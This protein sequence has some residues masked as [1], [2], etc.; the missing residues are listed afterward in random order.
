MNSIRFLLSYWL[1][2][3]EERVLLQNLRCLNQA[4][5]QFIQRAVVALA[6]H[7]AA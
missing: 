6:Q 1:L 2:S 5:R 3:A 7:P 4:E